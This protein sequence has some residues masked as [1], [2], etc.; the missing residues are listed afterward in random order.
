MS[1]AKTLADAISDRLKTITT[2]NSDVTYLTDIGTK[3]S[4]GKLKVTIDSVPCIF[5]IEGDE[6]L[7]DDSGAANTPATMRPVAAKLRQRYIIEAH[8]ACDPDNPN[9]AAHDAAED[10]KRAMFKGDRTFGGI[11]RNLN[12]VGKTIGRREDGVAVVPVFVQIDAVFVEDL[13]AP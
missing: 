5:L 9:D 2:D 13:T 4:R 12:Y 8:I 7:L 10:I 3:V 6:K 11:V 1:V